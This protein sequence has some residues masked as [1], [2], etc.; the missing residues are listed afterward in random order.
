M[1]GSDTSGIGGPLNDSGHESALSP[2]GSARRGEILE[3][4]Y[5]AQR[6]RL[7]RRTAAR[8]A[9]IAAPVIAL[10]ATVLI[11][12]AG[13]T[14][15]AP[16]SPIPGPS[17]IA[18]VSPPAPLIPSPPVIESSP[19]ESLI[20]RVEWIQTDPDI[21]ARYAV[22]PPPPP[23]DTY[24]DDDALLTLLAQAGRPTG[25]I[26]TQGRV[27][28]TSGTIDNDQPASGPGTLLPIPTSV[29]QG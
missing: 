28:L 16:A 9:A 20:A 7:R 27:I 15:S 23:P 11:V 17:P 26:R 10:A 21:L 12:Q 24:I 1:D 29:N 14:P 3:R 4:L 18:H 5:S 6:S 25:L 8:S 22:A 13:R 19:P 2:L